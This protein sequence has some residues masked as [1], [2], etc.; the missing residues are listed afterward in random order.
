MLNFQNRLVLGNEGNSNEFVS[1]DC[2]FSHFLMQGF[3]ILPR[4]SVRERN[5]T[6]EPQGLLIHLAKV[7]FFL[8]EIG[9]AN[10]AQLVSSIL[11]DCISGVNISPKN[12]ITGKKL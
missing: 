12:R 2:V 11:E 8:I 9:S 6:S 5:E 1:F 4:V 7:G 10:L 3:C